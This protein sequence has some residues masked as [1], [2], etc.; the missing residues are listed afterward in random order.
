[1]YIWFRF[2]DPLH[3][4]WFFWSHFSKSQHAAG[5]NVAELLTQPSIWLNQKK[6]ASCSF[7]SPKGNEK[8][9]HQM[10]LCR[11]FWVRVHTVLYLNIWIDVHICMSYIFWKKRFFLA[12]FSVCSFGE[13]AHVFWSVQEWCGNIQVGDHGPTICLPPH[14]KYITGFSIRAFPPLVSHRG[15]GTLTSHK[16]KNAGSKG[17]KVH[18]DFFWLSCSLSIFNLFLAFDITHIWIYNYIYIIY[19]MC[20]VLCVI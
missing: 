6:D 10:V 9:T 19:Y 20:Y 18:P 2:T 4:C 12:I 7:T 5:E 15:G 13:S 3:H 8:E 17:G 14:Q 16:V 11:F 1:M